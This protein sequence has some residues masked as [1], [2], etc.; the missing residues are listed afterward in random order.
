MLHPEALQH[1]AMAT[2]TLVP[3]SF[4]AMAPYPA[5]APHPAMHPFATPASFYVPMA[6]CQQPVP[7]YVQQLYCATLF[8]STQG[9]AFREF[10]EPP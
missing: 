7:L 9:E 3:A 2:M 6:V 1:A 10:G 4:P 8:P 5:M